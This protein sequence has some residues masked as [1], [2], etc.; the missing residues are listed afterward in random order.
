[1]FNTKNQA[2]FVDPAT[3]DLNLDANI[4]KT[5]TVYPKSN[6]PVSFLVKALK[7]G[8]LEIRLNASIM[9]GVISDNFKK[10]IKVLPEDIVLFRTE[11]IQFYGD[12]SSSQSFYIYLDIDEKAVDTSIFTDFTI[13]PNQYF[14][15]DVSENC[16][17]VLNYAYTKEVIFL[18]SESTENIT[19]NSMPS[20]VRSLYVTINGS[21][22]GLIQVN[23]QYRLNLMDFE[24]RFNIQITE[25]TTSS[26]WLKEFNICC[27]FIEQNGD[28]H[29]NGIVV[30]VSIPTGYAMDEHNVLERETTNPIVNN[31]IQHDGTTMLVYFN[32]MNNETTCFSVFAYRRYRLPLRRPSYRIVQDAFRPELS[33]IKMFDFY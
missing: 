26:E 31:K 5:I 7:L 24:P 21:V 3:G 20:D 25:Q 17:V 18:D 32:K 16:S 30:E 12:N 29:S 28:D 13:Y 1:M 27:S 10:I 11:S 8:E 33:A 19:I 6:A 9:Q 23:W 14:P 4:T 2:L 15:Q 22:S